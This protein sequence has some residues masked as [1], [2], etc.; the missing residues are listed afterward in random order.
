MRNKAHDALE[1]FVSLV[2]AAE[3]LWNQKW[4]EVW[5]INGLWDIESAF[6]RVE[7][8]P[9]ICFSR[10]ANIGLICLSSVQDLGN[11][12]LAIRG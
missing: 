7:W 6:V 5:L 10:L 3:R 2:E 9:L 4:Y 8:R 11:G 1:I 12:A